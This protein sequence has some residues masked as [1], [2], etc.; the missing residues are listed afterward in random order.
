MLS[1]D[2]AARYRRIFALQGQ[3]RWTEAERESR[4]LGDPVLLGTVEA[5]QDLSPR[6]RAS[7]GELCRWLAQYADQPDAKAI[8]ALALSRRPTGSRAPAR[9][10][11]ASL[12]APRLEDDSENGRAARRLS[13]AE[14]RQARQLAAEIKAMAAREPRRAELTLAG[15]EARRLLTAPQQDELRT[16]IAAGYLAA[17]KAHE[18][19]VLSAV[20]YGPAYA[21]DAHWQ[22]GL[23]A[24]RLGRYEEAGAHF[25]AAA[26]APGQSSWAVSAAAYW[27]AR[28][29]LRSRHPELFTYWLRIAAE[30]TRTFYGLLAR[31]TLGIDDDFDFENA[32]FTEVDADMLEALPAGR[33][34]LALLQIGETGRAE[35]ELRAL[36]P[37][38]H[39]RLLEALVAVADR[40]NMPG[41]SLQ[42]AARAAE[43][44][45]RHRYHALYPVPHWRPLGGFTVD[46]A[47]IFAVM[48]QESQFSPHVES[49]LGAVGLMQLMPA[50][51][52]AM[53]KR[54]GVALAEGTRHPARSALA[55][56]EVNL[57]LAQEYI[58][59]LI[60][61][62]YIGN[63][64]VLIAAA[65][66]SG[67]GAVQH[68]KK[69]K[70]LRRDPL[71]FIE[72]IP[73]RETRNFTEH[74]LA[75]YWIY[76]QRLNQPS[77]DLDAL[78]A[79]EWPTYTALDNTT[80]PVR[81]AEN[82]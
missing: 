70:A 18:A 6:Y 13:A 32:P 30:H 42:L 44:D 55:D 5:A 4:S 2:D 36:A 17:G 68:W 74:V 77:P 39:A 45:G 16:L 64:L 62:Q 29:E 28:V 31:R 53:A 49:T 11:G 71:L 23:A 75:N 37:R 50:T 24:W 59:S 38:A 40:T 76:R 63:N 60:E 67:P 56:P 43:G 52:H 46:R 22:A 15:Y 61:Q 19:L 34:A 78:A 57:A 51:A 35:A 58:M 25:Q 69:E 65:Y 8:Y 80:E 72:S 26:R 14:R 47:L 41:L 66:N 27:A 54:T 3:E 10:T 82:R 73:S 12:P 1:A 81:H 21:A 9:P 33:R 48:R 20:D 7:Y 79:G